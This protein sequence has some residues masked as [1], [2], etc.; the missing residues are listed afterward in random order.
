LK[1]YRILAL[2]VSTTLLTAC[3]IH[4]QN[5]LSAPQQIVLDG[6][7]YRQVFTNTQ[8]QR[9]IWEYTTDGEKVEDW[10]WTRLVTI[11][12]MKI[13]APLERWLLATKAKLGTTNPLP[14]YEL[15]QSGDRVLTR[16]IYPP[17]FDIK[18]RETY[19]SNVWITQAACGGI[20]SLQFA[21]QYAATPTED[22][23]K[24]LASILRD[25]EADMQTLQ[26][27]NW[28]PNCQ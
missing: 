11:N 16:I 9:A 4:K 20:V 17:V 1:T 6:K 8:S 21:R 12:Q 15:K 7:T 28:Q 13:K 14:H 26:A 27:L 23:A 5:D 10:T 19:E 25:N 2:L 22:S 18:N 3:S 24:K